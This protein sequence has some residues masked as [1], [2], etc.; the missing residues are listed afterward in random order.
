MTTRDHVIKWLMY[1]L[2]LLPVL[3]LDLMV[4]GKFPL[5]GAVPTLLPLVVASVATLEGSVAGA[6]FG[7]AIGLIC[8]AT[9]GTN[10]SMTLLLPIAGAFSGIFSR[11]GLRQS[12]LGAFICS[13]LTLA[14]VEAWQVVYHMFWGAPSAILLRIAGSELLYSL[15]FI[16]LIFPLNNGVHKRLGGSRYF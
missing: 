15:P 6:G 1:S 11:Y 5:F 16:L 10:G 7:L 3:I 14:L 2:A 9:Y 8:D 13:F 4:V 12:F